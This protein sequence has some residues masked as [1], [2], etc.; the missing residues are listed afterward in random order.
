MTSGYV[1]YGENNSYECS[2]LPSGLMVFAGVCTG[3]CLCGLVGNGMVLWFLCFHMKRNPFT[4]YILNL[5]VTD[6]SLLLLMYL[7]TAMSLERCVS[8]LFPIWYRC[9]RPKH[10]SGILLFYLVASL[11]SCTN[12]FIYFLVGS[13]RQGRFQ[14]STKVILSRVFEER[15]TSEERSRVPGGPTVECSV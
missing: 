11:N 5:I 2:S 13:C 15:A 3:I 6:F 12:P 8:V 7:L 9:H 1:V 4:I 14:G 10:L